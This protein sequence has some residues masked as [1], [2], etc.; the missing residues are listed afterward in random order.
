VLHSLPGMGVELMQIT[1]EVAVRPNPNFEAIVAEYANNLVEYNRLHLAS[2]D[3]DLREFGE[4]PSWRQYELADPNSVRVLEVLEGVGKHIHDEECGYD[5]SRPLS[6]LKHCDDS[7]W[8]VRLG[9]DWLAGPYVGKTSWAEFG[10]WNGQ[11][12]LWAD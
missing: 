8:I 7:D 6:C 10:V 11:H 4:V 2:Y 12:S 5:P 3:D 1:F 9:Y